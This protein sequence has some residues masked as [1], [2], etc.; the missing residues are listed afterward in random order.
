LEV[1]ICFAK[2]KASLSA[3]P[4]SL[5]ADED[6]SEYGVVEGFW[7]DAREC[8]C[9]CVVE[10]RVIEAEN[11]HARE[12]S[13]SPDVVIKSVQVLLNAALVFIQDGLVMLAS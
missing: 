9:R 3:F 5:C 10:H 2:G 13:E 12:M 7:R 4:E 11:I 6:A 8:E 1:G